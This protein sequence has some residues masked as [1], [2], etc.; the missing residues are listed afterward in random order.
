V[1]LAYKRAATGAVVGAGLIAASLVSLAPH[2]PLNLEILSSA[3]ADP[4]AIFAGRSPGER[5]A[6]ALSDTKGRARPALRRSSAR[7]IAHMLTLPYIP[8]GWSTPADGP[9]SYNSGS[10]LG[11][12]TLPANTPIGG[13]ETASAVDFG[14]SGPSAPIGGLAGFSPPL[15]DIL[16]PPTDQT[17]AEIPGSGTSAVPEPASWLTMIAGFFAVG[18]MLRRNRRRTDMSADTP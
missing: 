16:A 10:P 5:S 12:D 6:G 7:P 18:T 3:L 8:E 17:V 13:R 1:F 11:S 14:G 15:L 9:T 4:L 2:A